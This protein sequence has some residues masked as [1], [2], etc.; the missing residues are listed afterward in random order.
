MELNHLVLKIGNSN[1]IKLNEEVRMKGGEKGGEK[2]GG[3]ENE[4]RTRRER[5]ENETR[6]RRERD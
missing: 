6:T 3:G 1:I 4:K 2:G 5:E